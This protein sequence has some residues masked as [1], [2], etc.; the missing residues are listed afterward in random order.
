M[1]AGESDLHTDN[2]KALESVGEQ[3]KTV[4]VLNFFNEDTVGL[5]GGAWAIKPFA[6][7]ASSFQHI[8]LA[9]KCDINMCTL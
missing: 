3:I 1:Y 5:L 8:V 9:G 6:I 2:R 4:D 7:L